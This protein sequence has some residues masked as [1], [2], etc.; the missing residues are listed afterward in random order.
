ALAKS[1]DAAAQRTLERYTQLLSEALA[2]FVNIFR[3]DAILIGGGISRAG[4][5]LFGR[6][7]SKLSRLTYACDCVPAP[8]VLPAAL[9]PYSGA[10]GAALLVME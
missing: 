9:G 4:E 7:N 6:L 1:G 5:A 2:G 3:P 8:P 10:V